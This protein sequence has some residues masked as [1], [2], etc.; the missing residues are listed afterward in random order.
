MT[1]VRCWRRG[2]RLPTRYRPPAATRSRSTFWCSEVMTMPKLHRAFAPF[3]LAACAGLL[4]Q[5]P[6][7]NPKGIVNAAS[8]GG[9]VKGEALVVGGAIF[10][11]FGERLAASEQQAPGTPLPTTLG[12][13]SV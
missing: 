9:S 11:I 13:T 5:V 2:S 3:L 8:Y 10:S 4:A 1:R 12:G 7:I 6:V